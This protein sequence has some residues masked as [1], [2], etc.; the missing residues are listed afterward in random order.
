MKRS[1]LES[2]TT[3]DPVDGFRVYATII[4]LLLSSLAV[5]ASWWSQ[6]SKTTPNLDLYALPVLGGSLLLMSLWVWLRPKHIASVH[7]V[8]LTLSAAYMLLDLRM[9]SL[10]VVTENSRLGAGAPWFPIIVVIAFLVMSQRTATLFS[11]LYNVA[12]IL[13]TVTFLST[14]PANINFNTVIQFHAA[15]I[16]LTAMIAI[17]GR[18]R[19]HYTEARAQAQTDTLTGIQNRRGMQAHLE[20]AHTSGP[21]ALLMIDVDHF[22]HVNDQYGHAFGDVVLREIA[23]AINNHMRHDDCVARWGGEEFLVLAEQVDLKQAQVLA[24]RL[25]R[26]VLEANPGGIRVTVSIGLTIK[27]EH[28]EIEHVLARADAA[29]YR[30]KNAGRDQVR[31]LITLEG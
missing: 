14:V 24:E 20:A 2:Q 6:L 3:N 10:T 13:I 7:L 11:A 25:R 26:A 15:N 30:A 27:G 17:F 5:A 31:D 28:D 9:S 16:I 22:K 4:S 23:F 12:A 8:T 21:Y 1:K 19:H 18:M 29:L